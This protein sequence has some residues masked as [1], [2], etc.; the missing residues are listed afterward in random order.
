MTRIIAI[1]LV[2]I[3]ILTLL[4][5]CGNGR[6][7]Y[8]VDDGKQG[9][10]I[11]DNDTLETT[12]KTES[13]TTNNSIDAGKIKQSTETT[14]AEKDIPQWDI[15]NDNNLSFRFKF[16]GQ[17]KSFTITAPEDGVYR[18][19][20]GI[21]NVN[22]SYSAALCKKNHDVI[23]SF[24]SNKEQ[25]VE[26]TKNEEYVLVFS[27]DQGLSEC[28]VRVFIPNPVR[29][30]EDNIIQ[31]SVF[32]TG[33]DDIYLYKAS[34]DGKYG[35]MLDISDVNYSYDI[36]ILDHKNEEI[37]NTNYRRSK[38][39]DCFVNADLLKE[40]SYTIKVRF[41]ESLDT[42]SFNYEI[43]ILHPNDPY[44][45]QTNTVEGEFSFFA[46]ENTYYFTPVESGTYNLV[47]NDDNEPMRYE[48]SFCDEKKHMQGPKNNHSSNVSFELV[49]GDTYEVMVRQ[50][51][52]Y[53]KY[54]FDIAMTH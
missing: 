26:L 39:N 45:L 20:F 37:L 48:V 10:S 53:G 36:I 32:Y 31:G 24:R 47:F 17:T 33:Q 4:C 41:R 5:G 7:Q 28:N 9:V 42:D 2:F 6:A 14:P 35:L 13:D 25:N 50:K 21:D 51:Q 40:E 16:E 43:N 54:H 49:G 34:S 11:A 27:Q 30:V 38:K 18:F 22:Q 29:N 12:P 46:Q 15:K 19:S 23:N 44:I 3:T 52:D 1:A 8:T